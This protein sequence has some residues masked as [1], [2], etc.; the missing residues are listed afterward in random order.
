MSIHFMNKPIILELYFKSLPDENITVGQW[1]IL[2]S[3]VPARKI[4]TNLYEVYP[5]VADALNQEPILPTLQSI[6]FEDYTGDPFALSTKGYLYR[7]NPTY[8]RI[9]KKIIKKKAWESPK[10]FY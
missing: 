1:V 5:N 6:S 10:V 3:E 2:W 8:T 9:G 7:Q 4:G